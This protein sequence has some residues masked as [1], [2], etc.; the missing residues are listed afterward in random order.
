MGHRVPED[1]G[2]I[3]NWN[4]I[5]EITDNYKCNFSQVLHTSYSI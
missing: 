1:K 3:L 5:R 2:T 4:S